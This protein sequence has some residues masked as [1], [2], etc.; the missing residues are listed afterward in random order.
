M[1]TTNF[2]LKT[3]Y[4]KDGSDFK[5]KISKIVKKIPNVSGWVKKNRFSR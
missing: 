1:G 2:V 5:D 4:E 3:R